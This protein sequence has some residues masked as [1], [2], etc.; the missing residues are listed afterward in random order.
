V[1]SRQLLGSFYS[2]AISFAL[3]ASCAYCIVE[4]LGFAKQW[5]GASNLSIWWLVQRFSDRLGNSVADK[6]AD[7]A[8]TIS[9]SFKNTLPRQRPGR[10]SREVWAEV[11]QPSRPASWTYRK[12]ESIEA[13]RAAMRSFDSSLRFFALFVSCL[14]FDWF[15][16]VG[17]ALAIFG[18]NK[19]WTFNHRLRA[20]EVSWFDRWRFGCLSWNHGHF[21]HWLDGF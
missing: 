14:S 19:A 3:I 17:P 8:L 2:K 10:L 13:E 4:L 20:I 15:E 1:I 7:W 6:F 21:A 16:L 9:E 12:F 11:R 5:S 18:L